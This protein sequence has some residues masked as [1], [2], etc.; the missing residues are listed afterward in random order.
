MPDL[1]MALMV[2]LQ[3]RSSV[4]ELQVSCW[5]GDVLVVSRSVHGTNSL[6]QSLFLAVYSLRRKTVNLC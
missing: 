2:N 5:V 4:P 3:K 1:T 6:R